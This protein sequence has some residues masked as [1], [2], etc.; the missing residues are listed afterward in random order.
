MVN[1]GE[2]YVSE[3]PKGRVFMKK[4]ILILGVTLNFCSLANAAYYS[5][6]GKVVKLRSHELDL[7]I[8][9]FTVE[10]FTS[11]GNCSHKENG[12]I[13]IQ[14]FDNE[15]GDKQFSMLLAAKMSGK[16]VHVNVKESSSSTT[17]ELRYID[18]I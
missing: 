3:L 2:R 4:I 8:N 9:W 16:E 10:G 7:S 1:L 15:R 12:L 14:L 18:L 6:T 11:A 13:K 17:C 5:A